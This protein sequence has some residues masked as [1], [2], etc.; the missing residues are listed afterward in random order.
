MIER[1][2]VTCPCGTRPTVCFSKRKETWSVRCK[3]CGLST[4]EFEKTEHAITAWNIFLL[5]EKNIEKIV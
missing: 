1:I 2:L 5:L 4:P 3:E